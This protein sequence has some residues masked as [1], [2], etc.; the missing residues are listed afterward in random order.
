MQLRQVT[1]RHFR[2]LRDNTV[3]IGAHTA[4]IGGNGAGK[5]SLLKAIEKFYSTT[6]SLDPDDFYGR[7]QT[8][9]VEIELTFDN[10]SAAA[11]ET[12]ES[13]VREGRLV[14]TRIFDQSSSSGRYYGSVLQNP[15]FTTIRTQTAATAKRDAYKQLKADNVDYAGLPAAA[16]AVAVDEALLIWEAEHPQMLTLCRDDGQFFGFQNASRGALQKF[17]TF[18]FIPAVREAASD[19]ADGKGSPI[20]RLL[21]LVVKGAILQRKDIQ[22]FKQEMGARY[23]ALVSPDN[24]PEL[25]QLAARLTTDIKGLYR[26]AAVDL[27]WRAMEE[28]PVPLPLADVS[29]SDDGFGGPVDR[30]GHGLQRAFIIT[31]LQYLAR[32]ATVQPSAQDGEAT[33]DGEDAM[34]AAPEVPNLILAIEEPELYQHPTKQ[35]H[36]ADVLR[37]LSSGSLPGQ[38]GPTQVVFASHSPMFVS[39]SKA[40]EIRL[41]RRVAC[42]GSDY[43]QCEL[44][45]LDLGAVADKLGTGWGKPAG[46]YT[47]ETLVPRLHIL[48]I[49]LAEGFFANGVVIV[50]GR[51]DKAALTAAARI[52]GVSFESAGVAILSAEGKSNIDRPL[53]IFREL[54]IPTYVLWDCDL[55]TKDHSE[56][57]DLAILRLCQP[58]AEGLT[59]PTQTVLGDGFAHFEVNLEATV[60]T[61]LG[62]E[63]MDACLAAA[64]EPFGILP[65]S[66]AQKIPEVMYQT[67]AAAQANGTSAK[68]LLQ[69]VRQIW[70]YLTGAPIPDNTMNAPAEPDNMPS[71]A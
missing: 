71:A 70:L 47:A 1:V 63:L 16:S 19:A 30:Q 15:D 2:S 34:A 52:L 61:D 67:L 22:D 68:T 49:E 29:L 9:P 23:Q 53:L 60:R 48:G 40:D 54:G 11:L 55:G 26:D 62:K 13:R 39:L 20:A 69:I 58:E 65:S 36:F 32:T 4:L 10:L 57:K 35:R 50:E 56:H 3:Q 27:A 43:K 46:T 6:K 37:G 28:F 21:E 12:F 25:G 66:D 64:C 41:A 44:R 33:P 42:E 18:V 38:E 5:S 45:A 14:I 31:L 17:T 8:I 59:A 24:M 51:S 7:D